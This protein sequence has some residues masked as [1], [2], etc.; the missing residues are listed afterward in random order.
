MIKD[1][2]ATILALLSIAGVPLSSWLSARAALKAKDTPVPEDM[3]GKVKRFAY[4]YGPAVAANLATCGCIIA[5]DR[6]HAKTE[7]ALGS[8]AASAAAISD[9]YIRFERKTREE[10][11]DEK[12]AEI[13]KA[14]NEEKKDLLV[15]NSILVYEPYTDEYIWTTRE[16]IAWAM[17]QANRQLA[18]T[19]DVRLNY[20]IKMLGGKG[21]NPRGDELGWNWENEIQDYNWSY[22]SGPWIDLELELHNDGPRKC[23]WMFYRVEPETQRPEDMIYKEG[24]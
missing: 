5:S 2:K 8:V 20:I 17:L 14:V 4:I 18:T 6:Y 3:K 22:Y 7:L 10:M 15:D 12:V 1:K 16:T 21:K 23:L 19:Y 24:C 13:H 11:G 9:D